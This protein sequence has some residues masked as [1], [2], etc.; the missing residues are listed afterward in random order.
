MSDVAFVANPYSS[1]ERMYS[2]LNVEKK[3]EVYDFLCFLVSQSTEITKPLSP[4]DSYSQGF[5][6]LF[7]SCTDNSFVEPEDHIAELSEDELF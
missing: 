7:G 4:K 2:V 5:F 1:I 3:K 6:E